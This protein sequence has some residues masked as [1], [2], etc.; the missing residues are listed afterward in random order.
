[1]KVNI[2][3][4]TSIKQ[5]KEISIQQCVLFK[6]KRPQTRDYRPRRLNK[7]ATSLATLNYTVAR[8]RHNARVASKRGSV[9]K[10]LRNPTRPRFSYD[11][12]NLRPGPT[13]QSNLQSPNHNIREFHCFTAWDF[14]EKFNL[15]FI[16]DAYFDRTRNAKPLLL[17]SG[18]NWLFF[19][20]SE[21]LK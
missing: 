14:C 6:G 5:S 13:L 1:M 18:A 16:M 2:K 15:G 8:W 17:N 19:I 21:H 12:H 9:W 20:G 4:T 7:M 11:L 10:Q 3:L